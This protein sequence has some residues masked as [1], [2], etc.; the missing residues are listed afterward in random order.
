MFNVHKNNSNWY[1]SISNHSRVYFVVVEV[2][3]YRKM[4]ITYSH[5]YFVL[6]QKILPDTFPRMSCIWFSNG[7][8]RLSF[9]SQLLLDLLGLCWKQKSDN[10]IRTN[11][12]LLFERNPLFSGSILS[13]SVSLLWRFQQY[14]P[15]GGFESASN[16]K[17]GKFTIR[18]R[19][20][21]L[22]IGHNYINCHITRCSI[23]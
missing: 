23:K 19:F 14:F 22:A 18:I 16:P 3:L 1:T 13:T 10:I 11:S 15:G 6:P 7:N 17:F 8:V 4:S 9:L 5:I 12:L 20:C 21:P 2:Y